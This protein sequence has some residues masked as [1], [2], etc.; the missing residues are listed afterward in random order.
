MNEWRRA[1][2]NMVGVADLSLSLSLSLF[3]LVPSNTWLWWWSYDIC[4][5]WCVNDNAI[6]TS[7]ILVRQTDCLLCVRDVKNDPSCSYD[8]TYGVAEKF[9]SQRS[10]CI[11]G[12]HNFT[13]FPPFA[14]LGPGLTVH[15]AKDGTTILG[16]Y[17]TLIIAQ[18]RRK[19]SYPC[20]SKPGNI[21]SY[22]MQLML[23]FDLFVVV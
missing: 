2:S 13:L 8:I 17:P 1:R 3:L 9:P 15:D 16:I 11:Q 23:F 18:G 19:A 20:V 4:F 22:F 7:K 21:T 10:V 5:L 6:V 12:C 14:E